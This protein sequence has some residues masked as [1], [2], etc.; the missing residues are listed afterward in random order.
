M[1]ELWKYFYVMHAL[2]IFLSADL[3]Q[4]TGE[5]ERRREGSEEVLGAPLGVHQPRLEEEQEEQ[6]KKREEEERREREERRVEREKK[7]QNVIDELLQT[8][9]D[10]LLYLQLVVE[11]F[12]GPSAEKVENS[13]VICSQWSVMVMSESTGHL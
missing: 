2:F 8:E 11:Y 10:Y 13:Q 6:R 9:K 7:R 1:Y 12:L 3:H 5:A 4:L